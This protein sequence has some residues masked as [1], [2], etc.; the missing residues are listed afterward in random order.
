[1]RVHNAVILSI[2]LF[3][4]CAGLNSHQVDTIPS[5]NIQQISQPG[6]SLEQPSSFDLNSFAFPPREPDSSNP[7]RRVSEDSYEVLGKDYSH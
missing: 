1:M 3:A 2:F 5:G 6:P 4:G 7:V